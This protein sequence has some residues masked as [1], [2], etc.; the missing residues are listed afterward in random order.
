MN[1]LEHEHGMKSLEV[2]NQ[3]GT[4]Y[5]ISNTE[6]TSIDISNCSQ[7]CFYLN[8]HF[9]AVIFRHCTDLLVYIEKTSIVSIDFCTSSKFTMYISDLRVTKCHDLVLF[10]K[11]T[12]RPILCES[13]YNIK[14]APFNAVVPDHSPGTSNLWDQPIVQSSATY[15]FLPP[16]DFLPLILPYN[17]SA[18]SICV[19]LPKIYKDS[20]HQREITTEE[21]REM[22]EKFC[23][24][25]PEFASSMQEKIQQSFQKYLQST[26]C[27]EHLNQLQNAI[28]F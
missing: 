13:S 14:L 17:T 23:Q 12:N 27:I 5:I 16:S 9:D 20:L 26:K 25:Y 1:T 19:P 7:C 22:V 8:K 2:S 24:K 15:L 18:T 21:R 3:V 4:T 11:I 28:F 10:L 6:A